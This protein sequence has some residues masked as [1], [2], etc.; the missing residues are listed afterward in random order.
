[1]VN[2][3]NTFCYCNLWP[4][5]RGFKTVKHYGFVM[6]YITLM[7][8]KANFALT[9]VNVKQGYRNFRLLWIFTAFYNFFTDLPKFTGVNL[10]HVRKV[11][12]LQL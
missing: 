6:F 7:D 12:H 11:L 2:P 1:M 9:A 3:T 5:Q 8:I 10:Q 4:G